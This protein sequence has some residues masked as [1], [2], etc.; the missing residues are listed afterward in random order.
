VLRRA[1]EASWRLTAPDGDLSYYGRNQE[2]AFSLAAT[3]YGA[4][5]AQTLPG[6]SSARA[7]RYEELARRAL[8]RIR[9]VHLGGP[10]GIWIIPAVRIDEK[11]GGL[12]VDHG[13]YAP[14]GGLALMFLNAIADTEAPRGS[15]GDRIFSDSNG[16]AILGRGESLFA[17][18]RI[19]PI[20]YAVRAGPSIDRP[21]DVRYD[22]GLLRLKR[23]NSD[24]NWVDLVP[25]RPRLPINGADSAGPLIIRNGKG[26]AVFAGE[27]INPGG[28]KGMRMIG[29]YRRLRGTPA[30]SRSADELFK[31][32]DCGLRVSFPVRKGDVVEYSVY[33]V[34]EGH[35]I[36]KPGEVTSA[37]TTVT[38]SPEPRIVVSTDYRTSSDPEVLR[39]RLRWRADS[40]ERMR[41]RICSSS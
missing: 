7:H 20:W 12:A 23:R 6:T 31:P 28:S 1:L 27:R 35:Y 24:G 26:T 41:V 38:A 34:N 5:V 11:R 33:L 17:T 2:E 3:A 13:G 18:Q 21:T 14:Y 40:N 4:R 25:T 39:A 22:G 32:V 8:E 37:G 15:E 30:V 36:L 29:G 19:G 16:T 9:D 10:A